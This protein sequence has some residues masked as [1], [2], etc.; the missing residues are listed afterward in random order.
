MGEIERKTAKAD[1]RTKDRIQID[2][3]GT[4]HSG[5]IQRK[6][7]RRAARR[8]DAADGAA[9]GAE[10]MP[11]PFRDRLESSFGAPLDHLSVRRDAGACDSLDAEAYATGA[12]VVFRD[13][14]PS[15]H[16]VAHEVAHTFQQAG[17]VQRKGASGPAPQDVATLEHKADEV[18]DAVVRG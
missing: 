10:A 15:L 11:L 14:E 17:G 3:A 1:E 5:A 8:G 7:A 16:T 18:A 2:A 4:G 6:L 9:G 12:T 13:A